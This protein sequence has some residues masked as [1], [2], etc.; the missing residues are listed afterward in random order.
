M[1][2]R[3]CGNTEQIRFAKEIVIDG[4]KCVLVR[5]GVLELL[6]NADNALDIVFANFKGINLSFLSK[7]GLNDG[8]R[9]FAGNFEGGFLYT[10]G[11]DNVSSC[12][13][14][15]PVHGSIHYRKA[16]NLNFY[17]S[18]EDVFVCGEVHERAL[19]GKN[20]AL[21]RR[22]RVSENSLSINDTVVNEGY[23]AAEYALLYHINYGYPFLD[24]GL[25][26]DIP[27]RKSEPL[28]AIAEEKRAEAF[29]VT[30][31]VDGGEE[32]V[33][34]HTLEKGEIRLVNTR[35]K[36]AVI[37]RYDTEDFPVTLEWK[38]MV[39]GDYALGI[40]PTF[41]RFDSFAPRALKPGKSKNYRI[42]IDFE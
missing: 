4:K 39:S 24:E 9:D 40:E 15:K 21:K 33:Y 1:E 32:N 27:A 10:C 5:N 38:S 31:P 6:F 29:V 3:K 23:T 25:V 37:M 17:V 16:Q 42:T 36:A 8:S 34:Y 12:V 30:A 18:G 41:T 19:F 14:G 26:I 13:K 2:K 11:T 7:N 28:T 20:L 35:K 22:Y